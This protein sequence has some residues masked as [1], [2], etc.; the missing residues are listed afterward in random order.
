MKSRILSLVLLAALLLISSCGSR[1]LEK[2]LAGINLERDSNAGN[3]FENLKN[4]G[5]AAHD[6]ENL[7]FAFW[8]SNLCKYDIAQ[9][10]MTELL[11]VNAHSLNV[12]DG[13][14]YY[15]NWEDR[16]IYKITV[17]GTDN[18]RLS[19]IEAGF[20]YVQDD[21]IYAQGVFKQFNCN[22]YTMNLDGGDVKVIC[23]KKVGDFYL[24]DGY[25]YYTE[26]IPYDEPGPIVDFRLSKRSIDRESPSGFVA[27]LAAIS[28]YHPPNAT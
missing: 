4:F 14:V 23:D 28:V 13:W 8:D 20:L 5:L 25:T 2:S 18:Q 22:I 12:L 27:P 6:N 19:N 21:T 17:N 24:H 16:G 3:T 1:S 9:N 15:L 10:T 11:V 7:Y 26:S